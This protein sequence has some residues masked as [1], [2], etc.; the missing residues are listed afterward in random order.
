[1][2]GLA[3]G[4]GIEARLL[5]G[6]AGHP[7]PPGIRIF[8]PF[9]EPCFLADGE[10]GFDPESFA[11]TDFDLLRRIARWLED[12]RPQVVHLHDLA[13]FGMELIGLLRRLMP[14]VPLILTLTGG[15]AARLGMT[16]PPRGYLHA[17]PLRRFLAETTLLLPCESLRAPCMA[18]GLDPARLQAHAP[19]PV[20][21]FLENCALPPLGR[22][23]VVACFP[24]SMAEE[25]LLDQ[26]A[27]CLSHVPSLRLERHA[28]DAA[29]SGLAGAHIL[30]M[31]TPDGADP[32][33]LAALALALGRPVICAA[34]GTR[35]PAPIVQPGRDGWRVAMN[36]AT[37]ADLLLGLHEAPG[38]VADMAGT[39][40]APPRP[41]EAAASL[42]S[43]YRALCADPASIA[44]PVR[45]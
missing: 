44:P 10:R 27:A 2:R 45:V 30:L 23:L 17:A 31:T 9:A 6:A 21:P 40:L 24:G 33:G 32:E 42:V 1:M 43:L 35:P 25:V 11:Q 7:T 12:W 16:G 13:P 29:V 20:A 5:C 36:A 8:Q 22:F 3:L 34:P 4:Q 14:D 38:R 39:I 37:L 19:L 15:L 26:V 41:A 28:P 18:F